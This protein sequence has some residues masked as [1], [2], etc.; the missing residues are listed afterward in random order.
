VVAQVI[1]EFDSSET[2]SRDKEYDARAI[3]Y[4][5]TNGCSFGFYPCDFKM[6]IIHR[7]S[8][9]AIENG[10]YRKLEWMTPLDPYV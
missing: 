7:W 8:W 5:L 1:V 9:G 4:I 3:Y 10:V 6:C 2:H